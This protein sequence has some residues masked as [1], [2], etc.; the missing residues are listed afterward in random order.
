M[1]TIEEEAKDNIIDEKENDKKKSIIE[2]AY[3]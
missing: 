2:Q 3:P 1:N